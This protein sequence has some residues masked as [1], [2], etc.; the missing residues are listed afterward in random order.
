MNERVDGRTDG[1]KDSRRFSNRKFQ[2]TVAGYCNSSRAPLESSIVESSFG[3]P[4]TIRDHQRNSNIR[5]GLKI[6][7]HQKNWLHH[8]KRTDKNALPRMTLQ[9]HTKDRRNTA[10]PRR[11][12]KGKEHLEL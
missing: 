7:T 10:R 5:N 9:H 8:L 4:L 2:R 1:L 11:R 6:G 3:G 12:C